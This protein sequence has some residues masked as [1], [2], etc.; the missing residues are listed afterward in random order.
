MRTRK[1]KHV[2]KRLERRTHNRENKQKKTRR[3]RSISRSSCRR[4]RER[5]GRVPGRGQTNGGEGRRRGRRLGHSNFCYTLS[6]A[7]S[8]RPTCAA[9]GDGCSP[10]SVRYDGEFSPETTTIVHAVH[11]GNVDI[12]EFQS[13]VTSQRVV[14]VPLPTSG[15]ESECQM[16]GPLCWFWWIVIVF[17]VLIGCCCFLFLVC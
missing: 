6:S 15:G 8:G 13:N 16:W 7:S 11:C 4:S 10:N 9:R 14:V 1:K 3:S 5:Q 17:L 2:I 12:G